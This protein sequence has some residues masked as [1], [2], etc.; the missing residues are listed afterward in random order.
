MPSERR[1]RAAY[2]STFG[3]L[4]AQEQ[5][6]QFFQSQFDPSRPAVVALVAA[7][8]IFHIAQKGVHFG[9]GE[10][11]AGADRAVAGHGG[12]DVV[13]VFLDGLAA[14]DLGEFV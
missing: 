7:R 8:R 14:A 9:Q 1:L 2:S 4:S 12:E 6:V 10:P 3:L 5:C 11:A 13:F